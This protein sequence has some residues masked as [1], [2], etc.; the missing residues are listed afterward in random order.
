MVRSDHR[1]KGGG[2]RRFLVAAYYTVGLAHHVATKEVKQAFPSG[3]Q[4]GK[5][6]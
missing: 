2:N 4:F 5:R 1:C 6:I 3:I